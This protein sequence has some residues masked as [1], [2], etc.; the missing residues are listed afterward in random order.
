MAKFLNLTGRIARARALGGV[1]GGTLVG[2]AKEKTKLNDLPKVLNVAG[3]VNM[4]E[5]SDGGKVTFPK[6]AVGL[7]H[8]N[9]FVEFGEGKPLATY[10]SEAL[11][12]AAEAPEE[13]TTPPNRVSAAVNGTK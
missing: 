6:V 7:G 10:W 5:V 11:T 9:P 3:F 12:I 4:L 8:T 13:E 2:P 1:A